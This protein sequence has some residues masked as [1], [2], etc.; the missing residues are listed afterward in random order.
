MKVS[1]TYAEIKCVFYTCSIDLRFILD[2]SIGLSKIT[3]AV[4][5]AVDPNHVN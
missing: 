3:N 4:G 2:K 1:P 5:H